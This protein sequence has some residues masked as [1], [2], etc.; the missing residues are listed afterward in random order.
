MMDRRHVAIVSTISKESLV[1]A[2]RKITVEDENF[3]WRQW[4]LAD[5]KTLEDAARMIRREIDSN[6][7]SNKKGKRR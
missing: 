2:L 6:L 5:A 4:S 3:D 1:E 7:M